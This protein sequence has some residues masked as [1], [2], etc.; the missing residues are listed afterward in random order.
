MVYELYDV[1]ILK[2]IDLDYVQK[3]IEL[4]AVEWYVWNVHHIVSS[5]ARAKYYP[6]HDCCVYAVDTSGSNFA[7]YEE[8]ILRHLYLFASVA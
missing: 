6:D 4:G 2:P 5:S 7:Q 3:Y 1:D 8:T